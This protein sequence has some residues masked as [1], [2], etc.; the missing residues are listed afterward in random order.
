MTFTPLLAP[1][2]P[3]WL[4]LTASIVFVVLLLALE[5]GAA[6][7]AI[8]YKGP[9]TL[10]AASNSQKWQRA[11]ILAG[12]AT[13]PICVLGLVEP[14]ISPAPNQWPIF[15]LVCFGI[16]LVLLPITVQ[17]RRREMERDLENYRRTDALI[18]KGFYR[19]MSIWP[20]F[21]WARF[22]LTSEYKRFL[23]EGFSENTRE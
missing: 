8:R 19:N 20:F 11:A 15:T 7:L 21:G 5:I 2:T 12:I 3:R 22:F 17:S 23:E 10:A 6:I 4:V 18:K 13:S 9:Y 14:L 1:D 16:W